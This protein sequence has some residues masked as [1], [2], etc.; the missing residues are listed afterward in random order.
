MRTYWTAATLLCLFVC[1]TGCS[2]NTTPTVI[3]P[4]T[5]PA[6]TPVTVSSVAPAIVAAGTAATSVTIT[7]TGFTATTAVQIGGS[8]EV[9]T[10]ISSTQ[11]TASVPATQ[12][13]NGGLL[14]VIALNGTAT[15]ASGAA[16]NLEIDNPVPAITVFVPSSFATG[17][18]STSISVTGTGF[19]PSTAIQINGTARSTSYVSSSQVNVIL[20]TADL[21]TAGSVSLRAANPAPGGGTSAAA[22]LAV[23]NAAPSIS[24]ISPSNALA[25]TT[26]PTTITIMGSNF[27]PSS[28]VQVG[29]AVRAATLISPS[30]LTFQLTAA[31]Q[32]ATGRLAVTVTTPAPGGGTSSAFNITV[33]IPTPTPVLTTIYPAQFIVGASSTTIQVSG[34]NLVS[35]S[36]VLWN[37]SPLAT[38]LVTTFGGPIGSPTGS[39]LLATVPASLLASVGTASISTTTGTA[40]VPVS[41]ALPVTIVNP[42]APTLTSISPNSGPINTA[43]TITF[44]GTGFTANSTV[45][46][47]GSSLS[48]TYVS[49][50]QLTVTLPAAS[51]ATPGNNTFTVTTP[52]PG[53][54]TSAALVYTAYIGITN[55]SMIYNPTNGLFY[56]S[57]PSSVGPPYGNSIVSV[58]PASGALGTPIFVGSEPNKLAITADGHSLWVGLD[59]ASAVRKV[60]LVAGVAG[61][62][63]SLG[64]NAG[65]YQSP[66]T[67]LTMVALPNATNSVV[68][69]LSNSYNN[70]LALYDSGVVRGTPVNGI[71]SSSYA[72]AADGTRNEI[73]AAGGGYNVYTYSASGLTLKTSN[74]AR[75]YASLT[76]DEIQITGG[77]L[78]TDLGTVN[79]PE[80]GSLLGTFYTSGTTAAA[81]PVAAD[82]TLGKAFVLDSST[83]SSFGSYNQIQVFNLADVTVSGTSTIP[84]NIVSASTYPYAY[85]SRLTRWGKNGLAFR[86]AVGVYVLRSNLVQDLSASSADLD[87]TIAASGSTTGTNSTYTSTVLNAGPASASSVAFSAQIPASAVLVSASSAAGPCATTPVITC[88]LGS[89]ASGSSAVV[90]IVAL[91]TTPGSASFNA[92]VTGAETDPNLANNQATSTLAVTGST[93]NLVPT[94][95]SLSPAAIVSG[96]LDTVLTVNGTGFNSASTILLSGKAL[97]TSFVSATALTATV[98]AANLTTLGWSAISVSTP[99][100][101]GGVSVALPLSVYSVITLGVNHIL[102][103]PYSRRIMASVGSGST[104]VNGNSIV[105]ITPETA[106]VGAPVGIG[107]QPTNLSLTSDG[108][109]LYTILSGSQSVARYNMLTN[110]PDFTYTVPS[111]SSFAGGIALRGI[112]AQ[113][114]TENTVA[115]DIASFSG[116][117]I[118]DFNPATKTAAIRGQASGPYSG[119]CLQFLDSANLFAFDTDTSGATFDHYTVTSAGFTYYNYNQYSTSTL[120][121]FGCFKFSGGLAFGNRGGIANPA[122]VPATQVGIFQGVT[123]GGT[124]S[125]SQAVAP[126]ASL[127]RAF[128]PADVNSTNNFDGIRTYDQNTFFLA[129]S[130]GLNIPT[131]EGV[132]SAY[133]AVDLIRWGQDGLALLTSGG[134]IYL[135]RG[136]FVVPQLLNTNTA[137]VLSSASTSTFTHGTGNTVLTLTGSNFIPGV[138]V[139]WNGTYRT[140]TIVD[141]THVTVAIPATDLASAGS[142]AVVATNPGAPASSTITI[143]VN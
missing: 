14:S 86:S 19:V 143:T 51:V 18:L 131:T 24:S 47:N 63:F 42:P 104:A 82:T 98:P 117:A 113:P 55:N 141:A 142:A 78:Y 11:V 64:Q 106:S 128:F 101:G 44:S 121:G 54:G 132:G 123:G 103:D 68:V 30:Q 138:A 125:S 93:F 72:L 133:S 100:P 41:N 81:G 122:T 35:S 34:T 92:Q 5:A 136:A 127:Q 88:D 8:V 71:Y 118:Y 12:L 6:A 59:G 115:L 129:G 107:S 79:D 33:A 7:G 39:Y 67:A 126:D 85:P 83:L 75:T 32:A 137:A 108:Q 69:Q 112:A 130:L 110:Q 22:S 61:L 48:A 114:G 1:L 97:S 111:N 53:G 9:T 16:V 50:T 77:R 73:Y 80:S 62:Q 29:G 49:S 27:L 46:Y 45:S 36:V 99:A 135:V 26:T 3:A 95:T 105:G 2:S 84:V 38:T 76:A 65:I 90:T 21:A 134:H 74:T 56:V 66:A 140:T 120:N 15:S 43:S 13:A 31:D 28:T 17:A 87:V 4:P 60:D 91:Q 20:T 139:T 94:I 96:S 102:Y 116:N 109:I 57:V 37:G 89:L 10:Y 40:A 23:N 70:S 124:F 25:G 52:A 58:D 119:S